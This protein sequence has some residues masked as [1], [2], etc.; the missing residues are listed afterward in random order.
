[1]INW[2]GSTNPPGP[3]LARPVACE[4]RRMHWPLTGPQWPLLAI[5]RMHHRTA[6]G[7]TSNN[8]TRR[9]VHL[10]WLATGWTVHLVLAGQ[11]SRCTPH[12]QASL[13]GSSAPQ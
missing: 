6:R 4:G 2:S 5:I 11:A 8:A 10:H 12:W 3:A 9:P 7:L 1:M 13:L